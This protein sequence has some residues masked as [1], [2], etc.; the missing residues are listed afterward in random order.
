MP[1][2]VFTMGMPCPYLH[3]LAGMVLDT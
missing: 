3:D 2:V 1:N